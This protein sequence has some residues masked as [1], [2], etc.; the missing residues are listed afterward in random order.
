MKLS[1]CIFAQQELRYL[2]HIISSAR[3]ATDPKK[4]KIIEQW[5]T[6]VTVKELCSFLGMAGYY[7][8]FA[9]HFGLIS[10]PITNLLKKGELFVWT[11]ITEEAFQTLKHALVSVP[12]LALPNFAKPFEKETDVSDKGIGAVLQQGGHPIAYVSKALG[13]KS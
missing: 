4:V 3:V 2:G 12:V 1:K 13:V 7:R 9:C 10:K 5:P 6:P 8:K 11:R